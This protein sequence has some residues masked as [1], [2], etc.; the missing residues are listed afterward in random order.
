MQRPPRGDKLGG[1]TPVEVVRV[2]GSSGN[3]GGCGEGRVLVF[4]IVVVAERLSRAQ[5]LGPVIRSLSG[6]TTGTLGRG[7]RVG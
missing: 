6:A 2:Q 4:G 1:P 7:S 5:G 3:G